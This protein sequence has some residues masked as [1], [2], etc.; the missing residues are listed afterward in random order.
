MIVIIEIDGLVFDV[1]AAWHRAHREAAASVDWPAMD[2]PAFWGLTRKNGREAKV[3]RGATPLKLKKYYESSAT[4]LE[5]DDVIN[6]FEPQEDIDRILGSLAAKATLCLVTLGS[7]VQ[8]R[9]AVIERVGLAR[10]VSRI[11]GLSDDPR[12]R[13]GE[14]RFLAAGDERSIV[15]A[16]GDALVRSAGEAG[17][18]TVGIPRGPCTTDRLH[19]AGADVVYDDME[20]LRQAVVQGSEELTRAGLLPPALG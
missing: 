9:K 7:N 19:R 15:V 4:Y 5:A 16:A 12:K 10:L 6:N 13:P 18:V 20:C 1:R 11:E 2:R 8:A 14:L 3:L 17:I